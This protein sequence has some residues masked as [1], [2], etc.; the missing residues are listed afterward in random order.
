MTFCL[1]TA[2]FRVIPSRHFP[3]PRPSSSSSSLRLS[4]VRAPSPASRHFPT[5]RQAFAAPLPSETVSRKR[6]ARDDRTSRRIWTR[7]SERTGRTEQ[8]EAAIK[9]ARRS[10]FQLFRSTRSIALRTKRKARA[11]VFRQTFFSGIASRPGARGAGKA[12]GLER[13]KEKKRGKRREAK[14]N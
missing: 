2:S 3:S 12:F 13:A 14:R 9:Y 11:R 5:I 10:R 1:A 7:T 6:T 8:Y 4:V